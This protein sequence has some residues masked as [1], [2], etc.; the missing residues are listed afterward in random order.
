MVYPQKHGNNMVPFCKWMI[1]HY[2]DAAVLNRVFL[3]LAVEFTQRTLTCYGFL[4]LSLVLIMF[5]EVKC[6]RLEL[7]AALSI[8][9][10][11]FSQSFAFSLTVSGHMPVCFLDSKTLLQGQIQI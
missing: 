8:F 1:K 11:A 9:F 2:C 5:A 3:Y 4:L 6:H 10:C 7:S